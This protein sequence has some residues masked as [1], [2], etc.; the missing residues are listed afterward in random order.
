M[1]GREVELLS[2]GK[3]PEPALVLDLER[4]YSLRV[5]L[6]DGEERKVLSGEVRVRLEKN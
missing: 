2:P 1:L 6:A 3:D 4:D 5:R